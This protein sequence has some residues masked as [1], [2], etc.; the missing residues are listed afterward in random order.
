MIDHIKVAQSEIK[1]ITHQ[2]EK[3]D[4]TEEQYI[5][6]NKDNLYNIS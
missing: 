1:N 6:Y 4:A 2:A 3:E 5:D